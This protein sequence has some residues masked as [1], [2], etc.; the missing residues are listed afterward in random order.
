MDDLSI[1]YDFGHTDLKLIN[2]FERKMKI[3]LPNSFVKLLSKHNGVKFL[4]NSF[5]YT[6]LEGNFEESSVSFCCFGNVSST[7]IDDFQDFD[8]YGYE[9]IVTFG[10]NGGGDYIAFDYRQ[11]PTTDNPSIVIM[12]HDEYIKDAKGDDKMRVIKI[13][14]SFDDFLKLLHE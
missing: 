11:N 14:D 8:I 2:H 3:S 12:Y 10:L 13:A 1:Q 6:D 9:N 5:N 4:N 7:N